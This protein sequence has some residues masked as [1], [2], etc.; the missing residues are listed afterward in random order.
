ML[1]II[2]N[3]IKSNNKFKKIET[4]SLIKLNKFFLKNIM[5]CKNFLLCLTLGTKVKNN[6]SYNFMNFILIYIGLCLKLRLIISW[7]LLI[8]K[9]L[10]K[11][12]VSLIWLR[13]NL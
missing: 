1:D 13:I 3:K 2:P 5:T 9:M 4:A 12:R 6:V 10:F 7:T 8:I 11:F